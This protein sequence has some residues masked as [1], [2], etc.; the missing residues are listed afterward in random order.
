MIRLTRFYYDDEKTL[1]R[2]VYGDFACWTV[3]QAPKGNVPS[4]SCVPEDFYLL[5]RYDSPRFGDRTWK[6]ERAPGRTFVAIHAANYSN[7]LEGCI[8][9]GTAL[10]C[11]SGG[12]PQGVGNSRTAVKKFYEITKDLEQV[13][14]VIERGAVID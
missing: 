7:Q 11:D 12:N 4:I 1:G 5:Q 2:L 13:V 8:A 6:L 9:L 10:L 14:M 3:E